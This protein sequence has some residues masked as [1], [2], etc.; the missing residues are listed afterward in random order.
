MSSIIQM[1]NFQQKER[2]AKDDFISKYLEMYLQND[3]D[4]RENL[5][6]EIRF[7]K[8]GKLAYPL[9][10]NEYENTIRVLKSNGY[11]LYDGDSVLK[12]GVSND[13]NRIEIQGLYA[14]KEYC[15]EEHLLGITNKNAITYTSKFQI[16][17]V[18]PHDYEEY[19][20]RV[21]LKRDQKVE[22]IDIENWNNEMKTFRLLNRVH[23]THPDKPNIRIDLSIV[24]S[25][26]NKK[27]TTMKES[28][29]LNSK[30]QYNIEIEYIENDY[31]KNSF[32]DK[33]KCV[34]STITDILRGI[35]QSRFP[36]QYN[37]LEENGIEYMKLVDDEIEIT[38]CFHTYLK[39]LHSK[40]FIGPSSISLEKR[41]LF[42]G[43]N[44]NITENYTVTEKAD[45][46]RKLL[47]INS[48]G[49]IYLISTGMKFEYTGLRCL[50]TEYYHSIFDGEHINED[51]YNNMLNLFT[52]FDVYILSK[53]D[54]RSLPLYEPENSKTRIKILYDA[55]GNL[56][57]EK[58]ISHDNELKI[59]KKTFYMGDSIFKLSHSILQKDKNNMF[60][61]KTDGLIFTPANTGVGVNV[62]E[63]PNNK[64]IT[65][66]KS[67]KWKP[68]EWNTVDFLVRFIKKNSKEDIKYLN[69]NTPYKTLVLHVGYD[70]NNPEH[71]YAEPCKSVLQN[72]YIRKNAFSTYKATPF[73]PI[74]P[75]D[76]DAK[77]CRLVSD[78]SGYTYTEDNAIIQNDTIVECRYDDTKEP[79]W[80]WIPIRIRHDKTSEYRNG[81]KKF[82]N[83]F[84]VA[85]SVWHSIHHPVTIDVITGQEKLQFDDVNETMYYNRKDLNVTTAL[86]DFHNKYVKK[87]LIETVCKQ[88]CTLIDL[89]VGKAGDLYKW[90]SAGVKFV[91]GLDLFE[92]NIHNT[93]DGACAR[94]LS[95]RKYNRNL[96]RV[97]FLQG[98][99]SRSLKHG[100]ACNSDKSNDIVKSLFGL[101][102]KDIVPDTTVREFYGIG[103]QGFDVVSCQ[104]AIHYMFKDI[105]TLRG[106]LQNVAD[107]CALGGYF[108][109]TTYDGNTIFELLQQKEKGE[110]VVEYEDN[111]S[112]IWEIRK[113]Y[114]DEV[115]ENDESS[116]G[117]QIDV[118]QDS[119]NKMF[120]E[121]LV[122]YE[123]LKKIMFDYGFVE[124]D[125]DH[126]MNTSSAMF[127]QLFRDM[128]REK[129]NNVGK[130]YE[131]ENNPVQ[132]KIS[133]LN[134][135]FIF[136]KVREISNLESTLS[137]S[138]TV[139]PIRNTKHDIYDMYEKKDTD[140]LFYSLKQIGLHTS[141]SSDMFITYLKQM[142]QE[143]EKMIDYDIYQSY[144]KLHKNDTSCSN[145]RGLKRAK[146]ISKIIS[147]LKNNIIEKYLDYGCG[148]GEFTKSNAKELKLDM[149]NVY[150]TDVVEYPSTKSL[151][152]HLIENNHVNLPNDAFDL[153]TIFMVLHHVK[154]EEQISV[155]RNLYRMLKPKGIVILKEHNAPTRYPDKENFKKV[156]DIVHDIYD[157]VLDA[158]MSWK[159]KSDYYS[160]YKSM[161]E[162]DK[163]FLECGFKI[164][165]NTGTRFS[166]NMEKNPQRNYYRVF[167]K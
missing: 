102:D 13:V 11:T 36:I 57:I 110:S 105:Q 50:Q 167:T 143:N 45:G 34:K 6:Y 46:E 95:S 114:E 96:P 58:T 119:I 64:K 87:R 72:K 30:Q 133:F 136:K 139:I 126:S 86:R 27:Y 61:Y 118:Y 68:P 47:F 63:T 12:I 44:N 145:E 74:S 53:K 135:Y 33:V 106:F 62:G 120:S 40:Y 131:L 79:G 160:S 2:Y 24:K 73:S 80:K 67:F 152:F 121:Y 91:L 130:A 10:H 103:K 9:T 125:E 117:Y 35:Q 156:I 94:Y 38:D 81:I 69:N 55:I 85:N 23:A 42:P 149:D 7:G 140:R 88:D 52:A 155:I 116:L 98:N 138:S 163:L 132:K 144:L 56:K 101:H 115:F 48:T 3:S 5:E 18:K 158:E 83:D 15:E 100:D 161:K 151:Q 148:D 93:I 147:K 20:F 17:N 153:I 154:E 162:W 127:S 19:G 77:I 134:R 75:A 107:S 128:K 104:F 28:K 159:D 89:A 137:S 164:V 165:N 111:N 21:D 92:D 146:N 41:H 8:Y 76:A 97:V 150:C 49:L 129:S 84:K 99:T 66:N 113:E 157:Y 54:V 1:N 112:P 123:F 32:S 37:K 51:R 122:N 141:F 65:W 166:H 29:V 78:G 22:S 16:D 109:G 70:E 82:G 60:P 39:L 4:I 26:T 108:I 14:I 71:S 43:E 142:F 59:D 90:A 31:V 25:A 124:A